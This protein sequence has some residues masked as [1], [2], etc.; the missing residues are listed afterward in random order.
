MDGNWKFCGLLVLLIILVSH[1]LCSCWSLNDEGLA[2][3]KLRER[4]V[5]DPFGA[6]GN[7]KSSDTENDPCSWFGVECSGGKVVILNLKDLCL[8]GALAPELRRL[9]HIKSIILRNNSF[10]GII[11]EGFG[12]LMELEVLDLGYN[13]FTGSL[14]SDLGINE[15]LAILLLD[16]NEL[17]GALS[18]EI[19]EL[20]MISESQVDEALL[21]NVAK[22]GSSCNRRFSTWYVFC[23]FKITSFET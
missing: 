14:P 16:N 22:K 9:T 21:S 11:P 6:L 13:N 1:S 17:L 5:S 8:E 7:W 15:S 4:V 3:L 23:R 2:L 10:T 19:Y 20:Q 18:P 12:E